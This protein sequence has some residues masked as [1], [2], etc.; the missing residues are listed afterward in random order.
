MSGYRK[1]ENYAHWVSA[2]SYSGGHSHLRRGVAHGEEFAITRK[3]SSF[4]CGLSLTGAVRRRSAKTHLIVVGF[5]RVYGCVRLLRLESEETMSG[6]CRSH[7]GES[8]RVVGVAEHAQVLVF[9]LAG[10][11]LVGVDAGDELFPL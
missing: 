6:L 8:I 5:M 1:R 3:R 2:Y 10:R 4:L 9:A 11:R 7:S